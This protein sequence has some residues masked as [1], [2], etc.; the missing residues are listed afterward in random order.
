M[1]HFREKFINNPFSYIDRGGVFLQ[2]N[3][4]GLLFII[5]TA[6]ISGVSIFLNAFGVQGLDP[7]TFTGAKNF[8]VVIFLLSILALS[9]KFS[10]LKDLSRKQFALLVLIG[11]VGG[12][13]PFLLFFKGLSMGTGAAGA[14]MHKTMIV[15]VA[16]GALLFLKEKLNWKL[17]VGALAI[18]AG[19]FLLLRLT[20][21]SLSEGLL[22]T[23]AAALLWS[24][25]ILLSK[26]LLKD[27]SGLTVAFGRMAFGSIFIFAFLFVTGRTTELLSWSSTSW[28]WVFVT[29]LFLLGYVWTFYNGLKLVQASTAVAILSLGAVITTLLQIAFLGKAVMIS[30]VIG[31]FLILSGAALF[32]ILQKKTG[33]KLV[34]PLKQ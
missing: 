9:F 15:W 2:T 6:L 22:Y 13:L 11:L 17:V 12:S 28:L 25:E 19:N 34:L 8:L 16:F 4:K 5:A 20:G 10:E 21:I 1:K 14:F 18:L 29:S 3:N 7:F 30:E 26:R 33:K 31:L 32:L 27:V 23:F 24:V